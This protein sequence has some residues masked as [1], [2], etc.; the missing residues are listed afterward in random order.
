MRMREQR[1]F[2]ATLER[3]GDRLS[4]LIQVFEPVRFGDYQERIKPGAFRK[5]INEAKITFTIDGQVLAD[6]KGGTLTLRENK[7]GLWFSCKLEIENQ[8]VMLEKINGRINMNLGI[9][10]IRDTWHRGTDKVF[11]RELREIALHDISAAF[12]SRHRDSE[13]Q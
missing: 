3:G 2:R 6:T 5:T 8:D 10:L 13:T 7:I 9:S 11:I 12:K 1:T 4:G